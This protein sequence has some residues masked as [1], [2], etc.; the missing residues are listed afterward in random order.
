MVLFTD[1]G[2]NINFIRRAGLVTLYVSAAKNIQLVYQITKLM[3]N[4]CL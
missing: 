4:N 3:F 1:G 2:L